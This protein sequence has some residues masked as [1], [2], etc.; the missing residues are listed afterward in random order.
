MR[1]AC[2]RKF[3]AESSAQRWCTLEWSSSPLGRGTKNEKQLSLYLVSIAIWNFIG[4]SNFI[5]SFIVKNILNS[6]TPQTLLSQAFRGLHFR[7]PGR[8]IAQKS[9]LSLVILSIY[10]GFLAWYNNDI[11]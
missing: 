2:S 7:R 4:F 11:R 8:R 3:A 10:V 1:T 6:P 5:S 9:F